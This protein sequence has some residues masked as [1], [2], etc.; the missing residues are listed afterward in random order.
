MLESRDIPSDIPL[1]LKERMRMTGY[2]NVTENR[3]F[4]PLNHGGEAGKLMWYVIK[5]VFKTSS[6]L[7]LFSWIGEITIMVI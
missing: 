7:I 5:T 6:I 4:L 1:Q 3:S 2:V